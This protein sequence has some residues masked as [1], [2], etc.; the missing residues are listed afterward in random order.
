MPAS[1]ERDPLVNRLDTATYGATAANDASHPNNPTY[2]VNRNLWSYVTF[3]WMEPLLRKGKRQ[4]LK[5]EDL[6]AFNA[7]NSARSASDV[8]LPFWRKL[9]EYQRATASG[10]QQQQP[11][12]FAWTLAK[13]LM[14]RILLA[15]GLELL[16]VAT[17]TV[18]PLMISEVLAVLDPTADHSRLW[19]HSAHHYGVAYFLMTLMSIVCG[20]AR[21]SLLLDIKIHT[22]SILIGETFRKAFRLT[23]GARA[24]TSAGQIN[25][26]VDSDIT[27]ISALPNRL[28]TFLTA[29]LQIILAL[30]FL[31]RELGASTWITAGVYVGMG[32]GTTWL[33]QYRMRAEDSYMSFLDERTTLLRDFIQS[34]RSLKM[35]AAEKVMGRAIHSVRES[36]LHVLVT[37]LRW[38][39]IVLLFLIIQQDAIPTIAITAFYLFGGKLTASSAFTVLAF[40]SALQDPSSEMENVTMEIAAA[41]PSIARLSRFLTKPEETG[42]HIT[43]MTEQSDAAAAI[44][45]DVATFSYDPAAELNHDE[46]SPLFR[47]KE[48]SL[49]IPRGSFVACV[50]VVG[51][52]KSTFLSA[53]VGSVS[54][55]GGSSTVNGSVAYCS[56][57]PWIISGTIENNIKGFARAASDRVVKD[58]VEATCLDQDLALLPQGLQTRIGERGINLSGGQKS[59]LA[60]ARAIARD[61]DVYVLDEPFGALDALVGRSIVEQTLLKRL[62]GKTVILATHQL[63]VACKADIVLVFEKGRIVEQGSVS[64]LKRTPR[65]IF[66][67]MVASLPDESE[68]QTFEDE[69]HRDMALGSVADDTLGALA[70]FQ[71]SQVV[72]EDRRVGFVK[73]GV[74]KSYF[75][76]AGFM[77]IL[78][79]ALLPLA[80]AADALAQISLVVWSSNAFGW[81]DSKYF[82]MFGSLGLMRSVFALLTAASCFITCY[83]ASLAYH[84]KALDGLVNA[85][86]WW[87]DHQPVGRI[88]NRMG[89]DV[90]MLDVE[91]PP[92]LENLSANAT[93][94]GG[95][96][97]VLV[98]GSP[99]MLLLFAAMSIPAALAFQYFQASYRELKRLS[100][101]L[102]SPLSAHVSESLDGLSTIMIY[103]WVDA[104]VARQEETVDLAN[105]SIL[106]LGSARSWVFFRLRTLS[107]FIILTTLV[108]AGA[109]FI[110]ASATGLLL[111]ASI[112]IPSLLNSTLFLL[113]DAES[114]FNAVERLDHYANHLPKEKAQGPFKV[115]YDWPTEGAI[116]FE[117]VSIA[118][119]SGAPVIKNLNLKIHAGEHI[120]LVGRTGAG[121]STLAAALFRLMELSSGRIRIDGQDI[122]DVDLEILRTRLMII[123]QEPFV[124]TGTY[125][126]N[127]DRNDGCTEPALWH[128]LELVGMKEYVAAQDLKLDAPV[129][130]ESLSCGQRQILVMAKALLRK[131]L[132]ILILDESTAAVDD[133]ADSRIGELIKDHFKNTTVICVAHR[134]TTI[135]AFDRVALMREGEIV[136]CGPPNELLTSAEPSLLS[137]LVESTGQVNAAVIRD[138][139]AKKHRTTS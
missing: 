24:T 77:A 1:E 98:F 84:K 31:A 86:V 44:C 89:A 27:K 95:S 57:V 78:P 62:R 49:S 97:I 123:P 132:R 76:T 61:P 104:F 138:I 112:A 102:Q 131:D 79:L 85:P 122:A 83:R 52:G 19:F 7:A 12:H 125:R 120:G 26:F 55:V 59:R 121:K 133:E 106:L 48:L 88:L 41:V 103:G 30:Y 58:A 73:A 111:V 92:L 90:E 81:S 80:V 64:D 116:S 129:R 29:A 107:S 15:L 109:G 87:Y 9:A 115:S 124:S 75:K 126:S 3:S 134:L 63:H 113:C 99:Y 91:F 33:T 139:S 37:L 128:A 6:P 25:S 65:S 105:K 10:Q 50:G 137:E 22:R 56:Q 108:L 135:A 127:L 46:V 18:M 100:S 60:L 71:T 43:Q 54:L 13:H 40:L 23:L 53:L 16:V 4:P 74:Y 67:N 130:E 101:L 66:A 72:A 45:M 68:E 17:S 34:V 36:Q 14:P 11:P 28:I 5:E 96:I 32:V 35:E 47:L 117:D 70:A 93:G 114:S 82:A 118:Y 51:S 136:E 8:M 69:A 119:G 42:E 39:A 94:L 110:P 21:G 20:Y 2:V 38:E